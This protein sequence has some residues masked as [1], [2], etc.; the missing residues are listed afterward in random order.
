[1]G[2]RSKDTSQI[3]GLI[4]PTHHDEQTQDIRELESKVSD[5]TD[6]LTTLET[7]SN[8][9]TATSTSNSTGLAALQQAL[10]VFQTKTAGNVEDLNEQTNSLRS[11]VSTTESLISSLESTKADADNVYTKA[12]VDT[13][14][15]NL[16]NGAPA[17][18]DSLGELVDALT[19][20]TGGLAA[21]FTTELANRY[22]RAEVND[23]LALKA[24]QA[25]TYTKS[26]VDV[27]LGLK[28]VASTTYSKTEVNNMLAT[29]ADQSTTYTKTEVDT[30]ASQKPDTSNVYLRSAIDSMLSAKADNSDVYSKSTTDSLLNAKASQS[31][32]YTMAQVDS[33]VSVKANTDDVYNKTSVD[34]LLSSK[35][36]QSTTY[37]KT[38]VASLLSSKAN[39]SDVYTQS[40]VNS[41][42]SAKSD[43]SNTYTKSEVDSKISALV[44]GAPDALNTLNELAAALGDNSDYAAAV[45]NLITTLRTDTEEAFSSLAAAFDAITF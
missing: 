30:I 34:N 21:S 42:L 28:A 23:L 1:M 29:K 15:T 10:S 33:L 13:K 12:E 19:G 2:G 5:H 24:D 38:E 45:T 16:I 8:N 22:T 43:Q 7:S 26:E 44:D 11:R 31:T 17:A 18:L 3:T 41:L 37:T 36:N 9:L 39:S 20:T 40:Q 35:A 25:T 27:A 32:T 14:F 4:T 6:R